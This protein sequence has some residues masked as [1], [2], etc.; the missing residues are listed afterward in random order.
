MPTI[1]SEVDNISATVNCDLS[2]EKVLERI[3]QAMDS[4][5]QIQISLVLDNGGVITMGQYNLGEDGYDFKGVRF[6]PTTQPSGTI[7]T[8]PDIYQHVA[9][10]GNFTPFSNSVDGGYSVI[11]GSNEE[12]TNTLEIFRKEH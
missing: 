8:T 2:K 1:V 12:E 3:S 11:F 10:L 9:Q 6:Q 5:I 4:N 7:E